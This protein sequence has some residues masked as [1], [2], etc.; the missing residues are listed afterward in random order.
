MSAPPG[1]HPQPDGRERWWDGQQ[2]TE[3]FR[4]QVA[5][6]TPGYGDPGHAQPGA[7]GQYPEKKG[8]SRGAK[9]CLIAVVVFLV[10]AL[11][12]TIAG[13]FFF[14]RSV[15]DAVDDVRT[16]MPTGFPTEIPEGTGTTVVVVVGDGFDVG[17]ARV[18]DGWSLEQ[19]GGIGRS[20]EGMQATFEDG[21]SVPLFF[22]MEFT[23]ADGGTVDTVC[24]A[25]GEGG[26][27]ADVTCIPL[28][29]DVDENGDV[30][31]TSAF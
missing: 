1:W 25:T 16:S 2:W 5:P 18:E 7:P 14:A 22:T 17:G 19:N 10:L 15:N 27:T 24:S 21:Q 20:V 26:S 6:P 9:G 13:V 4:D 3:H 28:F 8:M 12:V 30:E 11:L 29:G 31:V 23:G